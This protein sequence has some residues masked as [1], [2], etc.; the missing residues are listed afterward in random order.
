MAFNIK[1]ISC[2]KPFQEAKLRQLGAFTLGATVARVAGQNKIPH[3]VKHLSKAKRLEG[4]G[5]EM[6]H[7][8]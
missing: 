3:S 6:I 1:G 5:K 8:G 2:V 4:V 7:V